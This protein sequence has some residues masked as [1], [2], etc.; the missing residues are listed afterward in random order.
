[1]L[2]TLN[3]ATSVIAVANSLKRVVSDIGA[4]PR[5]IERVANGVDA[6]RFYPQPKSEMRQRL[7]LEQSD[8]VL[9]SVGGLVPRKGFHRVIEIMPILLERFPKLQL[10]IVGGS[11]AEGD[12]SKELEKQVEDRGLSESV[13]FL[14]SVPPDDLKYVLSAADVFVLATENEGWAN[15]FLEA[16]ACGLPVVTTRVGGNPEVVKSA[17]L[18][19]LVEFG[20]S[21]ELKNALI[22]ALETEWDRDTIRQYAVDNSW[23]LRV[24]Q[25]N[26]I[27]REALQSFREPQTSMIKGQN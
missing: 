7:N 17:D 9:V 4:K 13:R 25:L 16:M 2:I 12:F 5:R 26:T 11:S 6:S 1:M 10:L 18:G 23:D 14:G 15:V 20:D 3:E 22:T 21:S 27:F 24:E 8:P 19:T